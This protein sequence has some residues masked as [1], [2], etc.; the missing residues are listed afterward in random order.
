M[1]TPLDD[2]LIHQTPD[3][4]DR[5]ATSDRNFYD[6][7]YFNCHDLAGE[8]FL[9]IAM[10]VYPNL[11]VMDA[12]ATC[13]QRN[14]RQYVVRASRELGHDRSSTTVGPIGVEVVE[15]LRLFHV[16][17]DDNQHGLSFDLTFQ[18][19]APPFQEPH[20]YRRTGPRVVMDYTR[21]TQPGRWHGS[22][23]V[24]REEH[25]IRASNWWGARDH[26]WGIRPIERAASAAPVQDAPRGFFW[27][28]AP[29][30]FDDHAIMYTVSEDHDGSRWHEAGA[31]LHV[32][33]S[34]LPEE[35]LSVVRHDLRLKP[36]TRTFDGGQVVMTEQNG[37]EFTLDFQPLSLLHMAGAG[38]AYQGGMW[39]H[40][41][42]HG[43]LTVEGETLNLKDEAVVRRLAGQSETVCRVRKGEQIGYGI[44]EFILF[45]AYEPYGFK[46]ISDVAPAEQPAAEEQQFDKPAADVA[47]G[48]TEA[49]QHI[50]EAPAA[51]GSNGESPSVSPRAIDEAPTPAEPL[52]QELRAEEPPVEAPERAVDEPV[53][54]PEPPMSR[55]ERLVRARREIEQHEGTR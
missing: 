43:P 32:Y 36:G 31:W 2:Y 5:V 52:P 40:G 27:N 47:P 13:V 9:V 46:S 17:C 53:L 42:Y 1:L 18:G 16:W 4:L 6:R 15:G 30:Q 20:F 55:A 37:Q 50:E 41:E 54:D 51:V 21:L 22:L 23:K 45:G 24:G 33:D 12:F 8:T 7:Y 28:W 39:R 25:D 19:V 34:G 49:A 11:G 29:I 26:S 48:G 35:P 38:Y 44:F 14:E 10:G 3:T